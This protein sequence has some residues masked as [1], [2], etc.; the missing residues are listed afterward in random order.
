MDIMAQGIQSESNYQMKVRDNKELL[1]SARKSIAEYYEQWLSKNPSVK[2]CPLSLVS[3]L[4]SMDLIDDENAMEFL[5]ESEEIEVA[6]LV[7][8]EIE[9]DTKL[10]GQASDLWSILLFAGYTIET[11]IVKRKTDRVTQSG[12]EDKIVFTIMTEVE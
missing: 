6:N 12:T 5:R 9:L 1:F 8:G 2:D 3:F 10:M 11:R 4:V 7:H